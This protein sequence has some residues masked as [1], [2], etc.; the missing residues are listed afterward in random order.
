MANDVYAP[1]GWISFARRQDETTTSFSTKECIRVYH[2]PTRTSR[3][4]ISKSSNNGV[5]D[6]KPTASKTSCEMVQT[7]PAMDARPCILQS[8]GCAR[9]HVFGGQTED[10]ALFQDSY[11]LFHFTFWFFGILT[12][13]CLS[14]KFGCELLTQQEPGA[15]SQHI[16][17]HQTTERT[18]PWR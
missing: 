6:F 9:A 18:S 15:P 13:S 14:S 1:H 12:F 16:L 17:L 10:T 4:S 7:E 2:R 3:S 11:S 5:E 8:V